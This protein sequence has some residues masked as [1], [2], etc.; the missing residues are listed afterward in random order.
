M[1][2]TAAMPRSELGDVAD[3]APKAAG[4]VPRQACPA[5]RGQASKAKK[6]TVMSGG[7]LRSRLPGR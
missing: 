3:S 1:R 4:S 6:S 7:L 2:P 5:D